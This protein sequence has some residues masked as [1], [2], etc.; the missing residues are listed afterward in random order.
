MSEYNELIK[1]YNDRLKE[2]PRSRSFA[3]LGE[4][5]RKLGLYKQAISVYE[6]GIKYHSDYSLGIIG[7][8]QC[9]IDLE[10]YQLAYNVMKPVENSNSDNIKFLKLFASLCLKLNY[11]D[12]ALRAYKN[13]LFLNPKDKEAMEFIS[14]YEDESISSVIREPKAGFEIDKLDTGI[15]EWNQLNLLEPTFFQGIEEDYQVEEV[16]Q[17]DLAEMRDDNTSPIFSHTLVDLYVSQGEIEKAVELLENALESQP[18]DHRSKQRLENLRNELNDNSANEKV[19]Q[20]TDEALGDNEDKSSDHVSLMDLYDSKIK[21]QAQDDESETL[22]I[23]EELD[24]LPPVIDESLVES[25]DEESY[26]DDSFEEDPVEEKIEM[27]FKLF[28]SHINKKREEF[29]R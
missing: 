3:P 21:S 29:I 22:D 25:F 1:K 8:A 18:N 12:Q 24:T 19:E 13:L 26:E 17:E 27:A 15:D 23:T 7:L 14:R 2:D 9:Y 20:I 28:L 11:V 10:E 16:T 5:Y 6:S 4:I